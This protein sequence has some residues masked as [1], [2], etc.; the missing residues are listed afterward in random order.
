MGV[1]LKSCERVFANENANNEKNADWQNLLKVKTM[2][3]SF[4]KLFRKDT[5]EGLATS[6]PELNVPVSVAHTQGAYN[7]PL[8]GSFTSEPAAQF[9]ASIAPVA[10]ADFVSLPLKSIFACLPNS[11]SSV[12][13]SQG[14]GF[15]AFS[16]QR[17]ADELPKGS[18]K[19][20]FGELRMAAPPGTFFDNARHDQVLV[21]LPL[22][23]ILLRVHPSLL[24]RRKDQKQIL[25]S[26]EVVNI[27]GPRGEGISVSAGPSTASKPVK[28][29]VVPSPPVAPISPAPLAMPSPQKPIAFQGAAPAPV[30]VPLRVLPVQESAFADGESISVSLVA[31]SES[32]PEMIRQE[33]IGMDVTNARVTLPLEKLEQGLKAGKIVFSW[34]Q[35][36]GWTQPQLNTVFTEELP[37]EL[38][39]RIVA[40]LFMAK[41]RPKVQKKITVGDLPDLFAG[42]NL[43][44]ATPAVQSVETAAPITMAHP[45]EVTGAVAPAPKA[46]PVGEIF[47]QPA[48]HN[49]SP[50]EIVKGV[51][52]LPGISGAFIAMQDGLLVA[53]ELP[54]HLKGDT[55]AAFLPQIFGRMNQYAKELQ[56]GALSSFSFVTENVS[57]QIIKTGTVYFVAIGKAGENLPGEKLSAVAAELGKQIQ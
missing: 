55:V 43:S 50:I 31:I 38:P 51:A 3:A 12:V 39:L 40:P 13:Q 20:A 2:F 19:I 57:W 15:V 25:L 14:N 54:P 22:N 56:L 42:R 28:P 17:I 29:V 10:P 49:W 7:R 34:K 48:K 32:W 36:C 53:A 5:G 18:V 4:K 1:W 41:H 45:T 35:I 27:F 8:T 46:N 6:I 30:E 16:S 47:G 24:A 37:L 9:A 26:T 23:E 11:L 52:T 33:I 44:S 21:E